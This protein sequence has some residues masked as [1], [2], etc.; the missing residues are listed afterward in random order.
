METHIV[1]AFCHE[2]RGKYRIWHCFA[3]DVGHGEF[4]FHARFNSPDEAFHI[5]KR[6]Y[7]N[8][9]IIKPFPIRMFERG[10]PE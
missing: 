9:L 10:W 1:I 3:D 7:D 4:V 2:E 5:A 6:M 8:R